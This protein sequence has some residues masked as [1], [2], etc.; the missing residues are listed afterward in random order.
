MKNVDDSYFS[1]SINGV[2]IDR[3]DLSIF[4]KISATLEYSSDDG[5]WQEVPN[6]PTSFFNSQTI[7]VNNI[8]FTETIDFRVKIEYY[9]NGMTYIS[10]NVSLSVILSNN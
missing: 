7:I 6:Q 8:L 3:V 10:S 2:F 5:V 9:N 4:M 1:I